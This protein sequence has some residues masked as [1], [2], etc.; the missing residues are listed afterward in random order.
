MSEEKGQDGRGPLNGNSKSDIYWLRLRSA[1]LH[2]Q[3]AQSL[4][5][6]EVDLIKWPPGAVFL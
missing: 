6:G 1:E 4:Q 3:N 5:I 2:Q